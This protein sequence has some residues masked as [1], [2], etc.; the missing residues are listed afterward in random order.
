MDYKQKYLKYKQKYLELSKLKGGLIGEIPKTK[1]DKII[2]INNLPTEIQKYINIITIPN[3]KVI[4]VGSGVSK[5][6][7][8]PSDFDIM[9]IIDKPISTDELITFFI[10]EIKKIVQLI[11][12]D[13]KIFYSDFKAGG[14]HWDKNEILNSDYQKLANACKTIEVIKIDIIVPYGKRYVEMSTFYILKS[15]SGFVNVDENYFSNFKKSLLKD[16]EF[17]KSIKPLKA[18]KRL[19]SF[20][21]ISKDYDTMDKLEKIINSNIS[22]FSQINADIETLEIMVNKNL[23]YNLDFVIEELKHFRYRTAHILDI[24]Y[25]EKMFST[26]IDNLISSFNLR[27]NSEILQNLNKINDFNLEIINRETTSFLKSINFNFPNGSIENLDK[28]FNHFLNSY[29]Y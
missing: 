11:N 25:D 29:F 4:P 6:Q 3:T 24:I 1:L 20:S 19:W 22:I 17:Y 7:K 16:V 15:N 13:N 27:N 14:I 18:I 23:N 12:S 26:M 5:I 9:N 28:L 2:E 21:K 8:F 10:D